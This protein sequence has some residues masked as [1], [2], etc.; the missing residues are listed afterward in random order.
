MIALQGQGFA[1]EGRSGRPSY[2]C[3]PN[4][5]KCMYVNNMPVNKIERGNDED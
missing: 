3:D 5:Q 2:V 4:K 1:E